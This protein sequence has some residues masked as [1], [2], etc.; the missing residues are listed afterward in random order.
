MRSVGGI[1][2]VIAGGVGV[3]QIVEVH[4]VHAWYSGKPCSL[5]GF[6]VRC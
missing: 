2:A 1:V 6:S 5:I 3:L 4:A